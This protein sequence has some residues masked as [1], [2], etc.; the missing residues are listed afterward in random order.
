[1][2]FPLWVNSPQVIPPPRPFSA[3]RP[4]QHPP[5]P[6]SHGPLCPPPSCPPHPT[7]PPDPGSG[8]DPGVPGGQDLGQ[9]PSPRARWWVR[10][11]VP[12]PPPPG[13][14]PSVTRHKHRREFPLGSL[15]AG[16]SPA[17][18]SEG[19]GSRGSLSRGPWECR[20]QLSRLPL[21]VVGA[22]TGDACASGKRGEIGQWV[23][24]LLGEGTL[25]RTHT[26]AGGNEHRF[27]RETG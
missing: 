27:Y 14:T 4:T 25:P 10:P 1:M 19:L 3:P 11:C 8:G 21:F 16:A 2:L 20:W 5:P 12:V 7:H 18:A 6:G 9:G 24:V 23:Q 22:N 15:P 26:Q 17:G 13:V